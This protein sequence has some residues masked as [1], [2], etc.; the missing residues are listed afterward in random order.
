[1]YFPAQEHEL[2]HI[3]DHNSD[4]QISSGDLDTLFK[5]ADTDGDMELERHEF[6]M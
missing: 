1:M 4:G 5:L 3:L 2:F 6:T